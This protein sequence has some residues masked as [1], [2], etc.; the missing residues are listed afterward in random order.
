MDRT[1]TTGTDCTTQPDSW[2]TSKGLVGS[3]ARSRCA[4]THCYSSG[5][6]V[7]GSLCR[8]A[9]FSAYMLMKRVI[10]ITSHW[11]KC[12]WGW[13]EVIKQG[14]N[15]SLLL[16]HCSFGNFC[17]FFWVIQALLLSAHFGGSDSQSCGCNS[18][19]CWASLQ[20]RS[21]SVQTMCLGQS[22]KIRPH[23]LMPDGVV[24]HLKRIYHVSELSLCSHVSLMVSIDYP[25]LTFLTKL[26]YWSLLDTMK[27]FISITQ[28]MYWLEFSILKPSS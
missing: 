18:T 23:A 28:K 19:T 16:F 10:I 4:P 24:L 26:L 5:A 9:G 27:I 14:K 12:K 22:V 13:T 17:D 20:Y 2:Y 8:T 3:R 6:L 15:P 7:W 25:L 11:P 21:I 1:N